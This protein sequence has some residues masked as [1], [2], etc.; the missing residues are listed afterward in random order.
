MGMGTTAVAAKSVWRHFFGFE[1]N[2]LMQPVIDE[3]LDSTTPGKNY[4]TLQEI[5]R[6][7]IDKAKEKYP[8]AIKYLKKAGVEIDAES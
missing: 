5:K 2:E 7:N 1:K 4:T 6:K 8:L 3:R